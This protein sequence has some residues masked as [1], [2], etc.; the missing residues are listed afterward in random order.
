[1]HHIFGPYSDYYFRSN[2]RF[3]LLIFG[4][5]SSNLFYFRPSVIELFCQFLQAVKKIR[6]FRLFFGDFVFRFHYEVG[7]NY[8]I[9]S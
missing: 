1:M 3:G 9:S 2:I 7:E 5:F 6:K 8:I 4:K